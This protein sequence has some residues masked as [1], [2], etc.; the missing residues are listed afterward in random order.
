MMKNLFLMSLFFSPFLYA[1]SDVEDMRNEDQLLTSENGRNTFRLD[2]KQPFSLNKVYTCKRSDF[3]SNFSKAEF[4]DGEDAFI[5]Q[6]KKYTAAYLD[7]NS[8]S[9]NGIFYVSFDIDKNGKM[10]NIMVEPKVQNAEMFFVD[11]KFSLLRI[12]TPWR[13][14]ACGGT[15]VASRVKLKL[16]FTTDFTDS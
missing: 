7:R 11:L 15:P 13:P 16:N 12:K 4:P 1:Q 9:L 2:I 5:K 3:N 6:L 8:Y 14:A 10:K